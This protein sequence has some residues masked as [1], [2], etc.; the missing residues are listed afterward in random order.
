MN[1][2]EVEHAEQVFYR[3]AKWNGREENIPEIK[4]I[5][6]EEEERDHTKKPSFDNVI[7][8]LKDW[9]FLKMILLLTFIN[10]IA[11][12]NYFGIS[13]SFAQEG[14]G[15]GYNSMVMGGVQFFSLLFLS[16]QFLY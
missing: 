5:I 7:K 10:A 8:T 1:H 16:N 2:N 6:E 13:Y 14:L 4:R 11:N 15:Y 9:R 3:I 12:L